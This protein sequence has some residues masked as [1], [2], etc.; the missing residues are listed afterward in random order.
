ML[1]LTLYSAKEGGAQ[2]SDSK[3]EHTYTYIVCVFRNPM[4]REFNLSKH[5]VSSRTCSLP[6]KVIK[7][8][9]IR[10]FI[11]RIKN[12]CHLFP[13]DIDLINKLAGDKLI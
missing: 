6:D 1:F 2:S 7:K 11:K 9:Y 4:E 12:E 10:E 13:K 5:I 8:C 3:R